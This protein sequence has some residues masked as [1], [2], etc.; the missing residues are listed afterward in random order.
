MTRRTSNLLACLFIDMPSRRDNVLGRV[1]EEWLCSRRTPHA[2]GIPAC[3]DFVAHPKSRSN[4]SFGFIV[5]H[6]GARCVS[7]VAPWARSHSRITSPRTASPHALP[8]DTSARVANAC[9][10]AKYRSFTCAVIAKRDGFLGKSDDRMA[11]ERFD[12]AIPRRQQ[13]CR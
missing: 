10:P 11:C 6:G 3:L 2:Q 5:D 8:K 4:A 7:F 1:G 9:I 12:H 13:A